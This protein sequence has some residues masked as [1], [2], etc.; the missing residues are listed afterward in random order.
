MNCPIRLVATETFSLFD[1]D[2][3]GTHIPWGLWNSNSPSHLCQG[4]ILEPI[5]ELTHDVIVLISTHKDILGVELKFRCN[6]RDDQ[7][8]CWFVPTSKYDGKYPHVRRFFERSF[9]FI[10][11]SYDDLMSCVECVVDDHKK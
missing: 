8:C 2:L 9:V 1:E 6:N 3:I 10:N 7:Q 4:S 5:I 11:G